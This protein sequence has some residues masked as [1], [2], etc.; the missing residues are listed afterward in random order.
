MPSEYAGS[1]IAVFESG[2]DFNTLQFMAVNEDTPPS[3]KS[4][5]VDTGDQLSVI[6]IPQNLA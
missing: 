6:G 4:A 5:H 2:N 1:L 3:F